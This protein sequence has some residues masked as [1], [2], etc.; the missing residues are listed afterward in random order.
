MAFDFPASPTN[1]QVF[2][3][4]GVTYVW[5]GYGWVQQGSSGDASVAYVDAKDALKA[6]K[7]Y[8]D[9]ADALKADKTYVDTQTALKVAKAG[10]T[11][12]GQ[13][14]ISASF[15]QLVLTKPASG[16]ACHIAARLGANM[17]WLLDMASGDAESTGNAGSNFTIY[18]YND[19][20]SLIDGPV[21]INRATGNVN[22]TGALSVPNG[23]SII[24]SNSTVSGQ[25]A[26]LKVAYHVPSGYHGI[27]VRNM[28]DAGYSILFASA[29]DVSVGGIT[30][31]AS[32]T[33]YNTS[34]G[35]DLKEDLKSFDAGNIIDD[36]KVYDFA[37]KSTGERAYG[38]IA[39]QANEVYPQA[40]TC[41]RLEGH[42][43][44]WGVD[45]SKYVP[46]ILQ[47]LQALRA[48]VREL[49]TAAGV[50][51]PPI[52]TDPKTTARSAKR[53]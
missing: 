2:T 32:A 15:P 16:S 37:W 13:L 41:S 29:A 5:N 31:T 17:R 9:A 42:D 27:T 10:D 52:T 30:T 36:T 12:T 46:V 43:E 24:G 6:D 1:G 50:K 26:A 18:R 40:V 20:G 48:R 23:A 11:M 8:V 35:A 25:P 7:T 49:E 38:V 39:Q 44:F 33:A 22:L 3:S 21:A 4:A 47:E 19:A 28:T 14:N 45:Y 51:P 34:S 53:R